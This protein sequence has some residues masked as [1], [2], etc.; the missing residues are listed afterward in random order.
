M[1]TVATAK[2]VTTQ[3]LT[4]ISLAPCT[5]IWS[6]VRRTLSSLR[7]QSA[8]RKF[9]ERI[10]ALLPTKT[11]GEQEVFQTYYVVHPLDA[12]PEKKVDVSS[13]GLMKMTPLVKFS[14]CLCRCYLI[15]MIFLVFYHFL[16]MTGAI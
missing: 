16:G 3:N 11:Q 14:L 10:R 9:S 8:F 5:S 2:I 6:G 1:A 12:P 7:L 4:L 13:L 15:C